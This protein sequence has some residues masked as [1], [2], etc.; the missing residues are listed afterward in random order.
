MDT[1]QLWQVFA[2][3]A[4]RHGEF[5]AYVASV[6]LTREGVSVSV[7]IKA[8]SWSQ[9]WSK[10]KAMSLAV[11]NFRHGEWAPLL[12]MWL[13]D[14]KVKRRDALSSDYKIVIAAKE[15]WRLGLG[16]GAREAL[17]ARGREAFV[18]LRES[19]GVYGVLLDVL[20]PHKWIYIR[21]ATDDALRVAYRLNTEKRSIDV[22]RE[23]YRQDDGEVPT[24]SYAEEPRRGAVAVPGVAMYLHLVS[25]RR[26]RF[27]PSTT[28]ATSERRS[29]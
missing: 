8:K 10:D 13:G 4:T 2:W 22:L 16:I 25:G 27:W 17:V 15:P 6:V 29:P 28:L 3:T 26:A 19:A 14:G 5:H 12:T 11:E 21:L 7:R 9:R 24:A 20:Q 23:A 18:K 1:T